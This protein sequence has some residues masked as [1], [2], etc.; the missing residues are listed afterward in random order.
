[1]IYANFYDLLI[2]KDPI[3]ISTDEDKEWILGRTALGVY[4][5]AS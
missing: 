4:R 3:P 1:M 2:M 5:F